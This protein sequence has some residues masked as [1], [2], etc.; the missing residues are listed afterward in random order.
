MMLCG[1]LELAAQSDRQLIR[2]GNKLY[3]QQNFAKAEVEYQKALAKNPQLLLPTKVH[4][5]LLVEE[6]KLVRMVF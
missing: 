6:T 5:S 2:Q 4:L 3:H 1:S